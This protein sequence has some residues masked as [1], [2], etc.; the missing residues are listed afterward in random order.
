MPGSKH[1]CFTLNNYTNEEY[2]RIKQVSDAVYLIMG[3][4]LGESGTPHIQGFITYPKRRTLRRVKEQLGNRVHL[5]PARGTPSQ[6]AEYC[7]KEGDYWEAGTLPS[8]QGKRND[9]EELRSLLSRRVPLREIADTQF[10]SFI[11]Y[12]RGIMAA[13]MVYANTRNW[14]SEVYVY[15]GPTGTGKTKK[16][17]CE[18]P[19]A[20]V[21]PGGPWFDGYD[22]HE[23]VIFDDFGGSEF[24][25]TYLLKLL[26]R[27]PMK[28]PIKG[29][30][31]EWVPKRI[32]ITSNLNP[33]DWFP[34]AHQEHVAALRRRF[35]Q[36]LH[37]NTPLRVNN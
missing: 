24:K 12:Q 25:L 2:E 15:W 6:A 7:K 34:N 28:V 22:G 10:G 18:A 20:Y 21:H 26:D 16:A 29:G 27:Y 31:V 35:T 3:K 36:V 32:F 19:E 23:S 1:W 30:F 9:L 37:F 5:E 17:W 11:R 8:G 4:E 13:R 14:V 33:N